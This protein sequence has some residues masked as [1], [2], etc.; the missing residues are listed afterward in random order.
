MLKDFQVYQRAYEN[1]SNALIMRKYPIITIDEEVNP[2]EY[3][4]Y[5]DDIPAAIN[6]KSPM[7]IYAG[8]DRFQYH[9][10]LIFIEPSVTS[11]NATKIDQIVKNKMKDE[12][13]TG[14]KIHIIVCGNFKNRKSIYK[15][16]SYT[17][18]FIMTHEVLNVYKMSINIMNHVYQPKFRI[19]QDSTEISKI[20]LRYNITLDQMATMNF[21]DPVNNYLYAIP[22]ILNEFDKSMPDI[23]EIQRP[24]GIFYRRITWNLTQ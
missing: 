19:I 2:N 16:S 17:H 23:I 20:L 12:F 10:F 1:I 13:V 8:T 4:K 24:T 5:Y 22:E 11:Y 7:C 6:S 15:N 9:V 3:Y 21:D 14:E 18:K